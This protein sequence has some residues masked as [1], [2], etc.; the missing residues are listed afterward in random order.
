MLRALAIVLLGCLLISPVAAEPAST[1]ITNLPQLQDKIGEILEFHRTPGAA[2]AIVDRQRDIWVA[3]KGHADIEKTRSASAETLFRIGSVSKMMVSLAALKLQE[4]GRLDL[5]A[6]LKEL[7]PEVEFS[8]PW[9][10]THPVRMVHLLEHTTG[11]DDMHL[12]EYAHNDPKPIALLDGLKYHPH[13]RESRWR[14]GERMSYSNSGPAVAAYVIEKIAGVPFETYVEQTFFQPLEMFSA[15]F[16]EP[17]NKQLMASLYLQARAQPYWH[18]LLRPSGSINASARDMA[19]LLRFFLT[20]GKANGEALLSVASL[21][22]MEQP[23]STLAAQAGLK[24]GYGLGNYSSTHKLFVYQG[25]NGG[26]NGG[27]SELAYLPNHG[28]GYVV[29][30]NSGDGAALSK[31]SKAIKSFLTY[32]LKVP[33]QAQEQSFDIVDAR[34]FAGYYLPVNPRQEISRVA[35]QT[36]G[37]MRLQVTTKGLEFGQLIKGEL[38]PFIA[39]GK[40][41]FR[42]EKGA[43][44]SMVL[45]EDQEG[46]AIQYGNRYYQ[47]VGA[48]AVY[49][50]LIMSGLF[51]LIVLTHLLWFWVWLIRWLNKNIESGAAIQIR[52][53]PFLSCAAFIAMYV[54]NVAGLLNDPFAALGSPTIYSIGLFVCSI[55]FAV[56]AVFGCI[57]SLRFWKQDLNSVAR[58]FCL[59][60]SV[61]LLTV[62]IYLASYGGIGLMTW[63]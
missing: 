49:G 30:I 8:N 11:W 23:Q 9:E 47:K 35:E 53:W 27:L 7:A 48:F 39:V 42:T 50:R 46:F 16:F 29:M 34:S 24:N 4:E 56:F 58:Y 14:P 32:R 26:V 60:S 51:F 2:I 18:I 15:T 19:Q 17:E 20:R 55:L 44:A 5:N 12:V 31:I 61:L 21:R 10:D 25:H 13:S 59:F 3:G 63:A 1:Q 40:R 45:L 41:L 43:Q 52:L 62:S 22:R 28:V 33:K 57:Q 37:A 38:T 36:F 6:T 54:F